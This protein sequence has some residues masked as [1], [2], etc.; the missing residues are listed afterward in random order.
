V[1]CSKPG[2][3][4]VQQSFAEE[5]RVDGSA[6]NAAATVTVTQGLVKG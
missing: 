6:L 2:G 5:I 1:A 4:P 3:A